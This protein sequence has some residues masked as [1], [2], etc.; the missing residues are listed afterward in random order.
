VDGNGRDLLSPEANEVD[1][2]E[3]R[4]FSEGLFRVLMV[5]GLTSMEAII[6]KQEMLAR[7]ETLPSPSLHSDAIQSQKMSSSRHSVQ[8]S[9]L[10]KN[11]KAQPFR[12]PEIGKAID[13]ALKLLDDPGRYR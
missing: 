10:V 9:G 7:G 1:G 12:L 4:Y 8:I 13:T 11:L 5:R 3:R 2:E 6:I